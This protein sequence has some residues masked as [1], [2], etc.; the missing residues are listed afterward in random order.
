MALGVKRLT[1][2]DF[3]LI[4]F[5]VEGAFTSS[6]GFPPSPLCTLFSAS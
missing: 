5:G 1:L 6:P 4:F 2:G 3:F